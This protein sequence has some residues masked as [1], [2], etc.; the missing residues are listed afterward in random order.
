MADAVVQGH[1]GVG[2]QSQ[3]LAEIRGKQ[4]CNL[5]LSSQNWPDLVK[6]AFQRLFQRVEVFGVGDGDHGNWPKL[7]PGQGVVPD[8][9]LRWSAAQQSG[10]WC[11][12]GQ[13]YLLDSVLT[14][15]GMQNLIL[16]GPALTD[17]NMA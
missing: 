14:G 7:Q 13:V 3:F 17:Q 1:A 11:V 8:P 12:F 16:V 5:I 9:E 4:G 2:S 15:Q 10:I 6:A